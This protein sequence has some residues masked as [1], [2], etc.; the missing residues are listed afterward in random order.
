VKGKNPI[1]EAA[2]K[3][4]AEK[5]TTVTP[6]WSI[7]LPDSSQKWASDPAGQLLLCEWIETLGS[8]NTANVKQAISQM[9][10][11]EGKRGTNKFN[12]QPIQHAS[13]GSGSGGSG[14]CSIWFAEYPDY[15][16]NI[17]ALGHHEEGPTARYEIDWTC[18]K[19][20][21]GGKVGKTVGA[22]GG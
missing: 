13:S 19:D 22:S 5:K 11:G 8:Y 3:A 7:Q 18:G 1:K 15:T 17:M 2:L 14:A 6:T 20:W 10:A 12:N 21:P 9:V 16:L 4:K